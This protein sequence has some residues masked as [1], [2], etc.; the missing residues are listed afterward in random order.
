MHVN[1]NSKAGVDLSS[2]PIQN[3]VFSSD[4]MVYGLLCLVIIPVMIIWMV[5]SVG[6]AKFCTTF[7][8]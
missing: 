2:N 5:A 6:M 7:S 3:S 8:S 1:I 4:I